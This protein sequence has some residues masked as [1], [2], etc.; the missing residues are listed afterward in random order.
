MSLVYCEEIHYQ[1][2]LACSRLSVIPRSSPENHA[3]QQLQV[4][5]NSR[6][7][8]KLRLSCS[9]ASL[10]TCYSY[11]SLLAAL[12]AIGKMIR[13]ISLRDFVWNED[14]FFMSGYSNA[15]NEIQ[16]ECKRHTSCFLFLILM[17]GPKGNRV[18]FPKGAVIKCF[19]IPPS[20]KLEKKIAWLWR[21]RWLC[22]QYER[23]AKGRAVLLKRH[24]KVFFFA[25]NKNW[26]QN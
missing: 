13:R 16:T 9:H 10:C 21:L 24:D 7:T 11:Y 20:S 18:L 15:K 22:P 17:T 8:S 19:V 2:K 1:T 12:C 25:V 5:G 23:Q 3:S 6:I 14:N 26:R 4:P